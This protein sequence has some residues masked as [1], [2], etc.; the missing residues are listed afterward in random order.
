MPLHYGKAMIRFVAENYRAQ[1]RV[2]QV[3]TGDS[4]ITVPFY[5]SCGFMRHHVD[6][7]FIINNYDHPIFEGGKQ[8]R[9]MIYLRMDL[10]E[11]PVL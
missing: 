9:D 5:E 1:Y 7:D 6:R 3:G 10:E 8:L 11:I 4:P 2:L